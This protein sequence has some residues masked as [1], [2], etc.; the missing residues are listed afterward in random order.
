M[1]D[2]GSRLKHI[3]KM[4]KITQKNLASS[5]QVGQSTIANYENNTRFPGS[6]ILKQLSDY[7][8]VSIDY[9][10]GLTE[11]EEIEEESIL[12]DHEYDINKIY[13]HLTDILLNGDTEQAKSIIKDISASGISNIIII[14]N[15]FIPILALVGDKWSR[16]EINIAQE[17]YITDIIGQLFSYISEARHNKPTKKFTAIFMAPPGEQHVISLRM[18]TEYFK[19]RGWYTIFIGT[20][21]PLLSLLEVIKS[22]K[23]DLLVISARTQN[24]LNSASYLV[25]ALKNNLKSK[26]PKVLLGGHIGEW[27]NE[28]LIKSFSDY[29]IS[30]L[31]E[32]EDNIETIEMDI[33]K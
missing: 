11:V 21:I 10:L 25:E 6:Q 2:F 16:D 12:F 13:L 19:M 8:E 14:E 20:S 5:I 7:L 30:S 3:R 18:S 28:G 29:Y 22:E 27:T 23:V 31:S 9:L 17:H 32:L 1:T 24:S 33:T 26:T 15:I 4:K